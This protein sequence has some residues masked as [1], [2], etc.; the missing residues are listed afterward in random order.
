MSPVDLV[1]HVK[2]STARL[3]LAV[4]ISDAKVFT[5]RQ[6]PMTEVVFLFAEITTEQGHSGLGFSYSK[7][8]GGPAQ[9][10]HAKEVAQGLIGEDPNDIGK[11]YAKLLWAGASVGRSGVATQA[12]AAVDIALYDLK[13]KR[14]GLPL[15]KLLGSYRDS[16]RTY[17]TSGGFLNAT[18]D[19]V[20]ARA[21]QSIEEG[22][23]G[24]KIKVGLPDSKEDLRRVAGVREHIGWDVPLMV[25]A[26]QQ[27]DRATALRMGRQL[28]EFNL[29]WIEEPLD[30]YDFEGHAHLAQV[31]DT[32]IAT[33]EMLASVAEHKGLINANGCDII[34]PDAPRV[35]GITQFL[36]LATL[37]DERGLGLA[38]H[39]AMEVHLHL[40][41]AYPAEPWVEHFDWLDPL[42]EER[43]ETKDG[44]MI[45]PDRPGL[46]VTLSG[47]ARAWTTESVEFGA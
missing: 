21:T 13:A 31:L 37:A 20:K 40:A 36:R 41:A 5:G 10:A 44:R 35:G 38:P 42:F 22:I 2:L 39:F 3:P 25:D 33:G 6:K 11:I 17:N 43:L 19:E 29:I 14:A 34:Q 8:A 30:A 32:P 28:E 15:A 45:V 7:R 46:G 4:P 18:L 1:R 24:I 27:W 26:N 47:Q 16:V 23:G 12:L 9:Y